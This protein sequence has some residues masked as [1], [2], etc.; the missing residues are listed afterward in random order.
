MRYTCD[1]DENQH[2]LLALVAVRS[3]AYRQAKRDRDAAIC[4]AV[5]ADIPQARIGAAAGLS[6]AAIRKINR[7]AQA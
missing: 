1:M 6:A 2:R 4:D 3:D 5:A 7:E